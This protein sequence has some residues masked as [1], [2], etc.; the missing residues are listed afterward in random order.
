M[1]FAAAIGPI[2]SGVASIAGA[3]ISAS[4]MAAQA[5]QEEE[6]AAYNAQRQREKAALAQAKGAQE[7]RVRE[8]QGEQI[9]SQYR[10]AVAQGGGVTTEATPL[11]MQQ[12]FAADTWHDSNIAMFNARTE[13]ADRENQ[14]NI[15]EYEGKVRADA[16]RAQATA[17]LISG[18]A[19]AAKGIAG[20]FG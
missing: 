1:A 20:A 14:A 10:A 6:I 5:R 17:S 19:G 11:L 4:A 13:Q 18:F 12:E 7:A 2:I 15:T 3:L 8:E 16:S 9:A